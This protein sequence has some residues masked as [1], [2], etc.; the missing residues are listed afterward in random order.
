MHALKI[1]TTKNFFA[2]I[3][4]TF[5]LVGSFLLSPVM[6]Q[7]SL[8][9]AAS[10][11]FESATPTGL[12]STD[13]SANGWTVVNGASNQFFVG[14][15][16]IAATGSYAA[17]TG[18]SASVW[19]GQAVATI[20]HI[21]RDILIPAGEPN[22]TLTFRYK[23]SIVDAGFDFVKAYLASPTTTPVPNVA[24]ADGQMGLLAGYDGTT[25]YVTYTVYATT[26]PGTTRRLILSFRSDGVTPHAAGALDDISLTTSATPPAGNSASS[27]GGLWSSAPTWVGGFVPAAGTDVTIPAGAVVSIDQVTNVNNLTVAGTLQWNASSNAM[28]VIGNLNIASTGR[29]L[30]YNTLGT[31]QT[32]NV[33]GNFINDGF[34]NLALTSTTINMNGSMVGGSMSQTF[35]GTGSFA[36]S[37]THGLVRALFY[38][39]T[40]SSSISTTQNIATG[41][42]ASTGGPVNTN[43][44]LTI[45]NTQEM[46]GQPINRQ[47]ASVSV[48]AMGTGYTT[49]PHLFGSAVL[50]WVS[51]GAV[52][53][54]NRYFSNGNV[55][56]ALDNVAFNS[57]APVSTTAATPFQTDGATGTSL[58]W[59]APEGTLGTPF[60]VGG[61]VV[62][63]FYFY[64]NNLYVCTLAG[65]STATGAPVHTSGSASSG[66][67][68]LLYVGSPA[69]ASLNWDAATGTVRSANL[70]TGG[71]GYLTAPAGTI[72]PD[73]VGVGSGASITPVVLTANAGPASSIIQKS[74][75]ATITGGTT[76]RSEQSVGA[77]SVANG[78]INYS[79][80]PAVGFALP[81]GYLNLVTNGGS[82]YTGAVTIAVSGGTQL[83]G[84]T[85]PTFSTVVAGGQVVSVICTGG[86][87]L[88][89]V[90]PTLTINGGGGSGATAGFPTNSLASATANLT[91][92]SVTGFTIT[93]GGFGYTAAPAVGLVTTGTVNTAASAATARIGI[94]N[95][96]GNFF[97]PAPSAAP[98]TETGVVPANR[99]IN[100]L[101]VS[102]SNMTFTGDLEL[103]S[104]TGM[105]LTTA[106]LNLGGNTLHFSHP[107]YVGTAATTTNFV[108]GKIKL[109]TPG[110]AVS[111]TFPFINTLVVATGTG[112]GATGSTIT[113]LNGEVTA[114][115]TGSGAPKGTRAYRV[116]SNGGVYG[117]NPTVTMNWNASDALTGNLQELY[118]SQSNSVAGPWTPRSVPV[119][120]GAIPATGARTTATVSPGP[121][122]PTGDDYY[123]WSSPLNVFTNVT[124]PA[125]SCTV[126]SHVINA[127]IVAAAGSLTSVTLNYNNGAPGSVAMSL[128]AG[129]T[130]TATIPAATPNNAI[131]SWSITAV[132]SFGISNTFTGSSY[133][134]EPLTGVTATATASVNPVCNGSAT[135]LSFV[136]TPT[137]GPVTSVIWSDGTNTVGTTD[138]LVVTPTTNT[139][140][141]AN[142]IVANC[143][144]TTS[145]IL[146]S[147]TALPTAPVTGP[148]SQCGTGTP[149]AF[150]TGTA[151]GNYRWYLTPTGGT[152]L[153]GQVNSSLTAYPISTPTTF[154]VS[155]FDGTCESLRTSVF[156]DVVSPDP[157]QASVN[158]NDICLGAAVTL[159][160]TNTASTP[161]NTYTYTWTASPA[162]GSG[163]PTALSGEQ[164]TITPTAV[165]TY[166]YT[167]T[168][169]DA[170]CTTTSTVSVSTLR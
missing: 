56:L 2:M 52:T 164:P 63:T 83:A 132:S 120:T 156:A 55:Y 104:S 50:P 101:T 137:A 90:P 121:I 149:G 62:N 51:G 20:S 119:G 96:T 133:Q 163:I 53:A 115:P 97:N 33:G 102:N 153:L 160:A 151:E 30:P 3:A 61:L 98:H 165:G 144:I 86:G 57:T 93:N 141:S 69:R 107:A 28:T 75:V 146:V 91:N 77:V 79:T 159:T 117:I 88:W 40:G 143:P 27:L 92:G 38:Q 150:A 36:G 85:A 68:T 16:P 7:T 142:L 148:S 147:V 18:S 108:T 26:T 17:F 131:V 73:V 34:A 123:A 105:T 111:R 167:V 168:A 54:G 11:G 170:G 145:S 124:V 169:V 19:T 14:S 4:T 81:T 39:T 64:G 84:G 130:Y 162:S 49:A 82:G 135:S 138:P 139:T 72:S 158:N 43:A 9:P 35:G 118:I 125:N 42:F 87:T 8:I 122:V 161:A 15:A 140:Y 129:N 1:I 154:Y 109:T 12:S 103:Y 46:Y 78:G 74:G 110:G 31:G 47:V 152:A 76:I 45:D 65:T 48:N 59:L 44:K 80:P 25:G 23:V 166:V 94:Y 116:N 128:L 136:L 37:A 21:Y 157:V 60:F 22:V 106:A 41:S 29:F 66:S 32:V 5:F 71:S 100:T 24:V 99:R 89:Q 114:A 6:A 95:F 58:L 70:L 13:F 67:A 155:I 127:D 113:S 10:G 126:T 134:D 112:T